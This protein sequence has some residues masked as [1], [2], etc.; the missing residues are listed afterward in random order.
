[1]SP[2]QVQIGFEDRMNAHA[3][4]RWLVGEFK[5][6]TTDGQTLPLVTAAGISEVLA[7]MD[8]QRPAWEEDPWE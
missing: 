3:F 7:S 8:S 4:Y 2:V 6:Q 1:M 5:G